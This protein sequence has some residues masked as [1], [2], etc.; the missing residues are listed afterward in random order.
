ML[1]LADAETLRSG[2][3]EPVGHTV[4]VRDAEGERVPDTEPEVLLVKGCVVPTPVEVAVGAG[5][6]EE[7]DK[8]GVLVPQGEGEWEDVTLALRERLGQAEE[9]GE[10][11]TVT[12]TRGE[13]VRLLEVLA[14]REETD[15]V[16][17]L[18]P[19]GEGEWEDVTLAL[20]ERLGQAEEEGETLTVAE[21]RGERVRLLEV[22][23]EREAEMVTEGEGEEDSLPV[24]DDVTDGLRDTLTVRD[25]LRVTQLDAVGEEERHS[26]GDCD[27]VAGTLPEAPLEPLTE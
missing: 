20:R 11:L 19:Q 25:R 8:V 18:V 2:E 23:A 5:E 17:V 9:E 7:T 21:T 3:G 27:S 22:L 1:G 16:G 24:V 12:E 15:K 14:E 26:V 10:T 6:R 4:P 13:R